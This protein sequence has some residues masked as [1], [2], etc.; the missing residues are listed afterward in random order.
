[1]NYLF[2]LS[3]VLEFAGSIFSLIK[4][5]INLLLKFVSFVFNLLNSTCLL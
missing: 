5:I 1:M 4:F 3:N 2:H